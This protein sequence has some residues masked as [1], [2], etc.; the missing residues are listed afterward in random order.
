MTWALARRRL[1]AIGEGVAVSTK[2]NGLPAKFKHDKNGDENADTGDSRRFWLR[3]LSG[4]GKGPFTTSTT[5]WRATVQLVVEYV[6]D[7]KTD[8]LDEAMVGDAIDLIK[9]Y[10]LG[11]NWDRPASG[12]VAVNVDGD[13]IAPFEIESGDGRRR[14]RI[15]LEV[16]YHD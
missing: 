9:A 14:L 15:N 6:A 5:W 8:A 4:Y 2:A 10:S 12:I 13:N 1:V 16:T 7:N 3:T 11:S